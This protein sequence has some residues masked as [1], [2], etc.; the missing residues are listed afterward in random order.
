LQTSFT[1]SSTNAATVT[2]NRSGSTFRS[3]GVIDAGYLYQGATNTFANSTIDY[4]KFGLTDSFTVLAVFRQ[5]AT[6][7]DK[8]IIST[9]GTLG[10]YTISQLSSNRAYFQVT[11]A[12]VFP[13]AT[14]NVTDGSFTTLTGV[15]NVTADTIAA[16]VNTAAPVSVTDTNTKSTS[17]NIDN[18]RIGNQT[19]AVYAD[20]E[21]IGAAVFR[22]VLTAAQIRQISNY[23]ANREAY[24]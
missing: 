21:F 9:V 6:T 4:L 1:E 5:W 18:F 23:F 10:G 11:D 15:R 13:T 16:Y 19:G 22:S 24:L 2:I 12:T 7:A 20:M 17:N 3:A 14:V 8:R